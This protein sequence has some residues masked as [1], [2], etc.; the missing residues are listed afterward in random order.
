[1]YCQVKLA[2]RSKIQLDYCYWILMLKILTEV[3]CTFPSKFWNIFWKITV[4]GV[5]QIK[6]SGRDCW[7]LLF[8]TTA[9][10]LAAPL[11]QH[12]LTGKITFI[13]AIFS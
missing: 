6:A 8:D 2:A 3:H 5:S 13:K 7:L 1:M 9:P 11:A 12:V 4:I 10:K